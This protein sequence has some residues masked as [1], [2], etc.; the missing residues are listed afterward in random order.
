MIHLTEKISNNPS[1]LINFYGLVTTNNMEETIGFY[2]A[3]WD[4]K[5]LEE[6]EDY[7]LI[8]VQ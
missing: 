3:N 2:M 1:E 8:Q 4:W 7:T 5:I 6:N